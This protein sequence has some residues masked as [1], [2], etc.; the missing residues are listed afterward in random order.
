MGTSP[1]FSTLPEYASSTKQTVNH[2][3]AFSFPWTGSPTPK[4]PE[5]VQKMLQGIREKSTSSPVRSGQS[6]P[7]KRVASPPLPSWSGKI[8][9]QTAQTVVSPQPRKDWSKVGSGWNSSSSR[10][11]VGMGLPRASPILM[12]TSSIKSAP[13]AATGDL[14]YQTVVRQWCFAQGTGSAQGQQ[15]KYATG[16]GDGA[17][18]VV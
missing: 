16:R 6:S 11:A 10:V 14:I 3:P 9:H 13:A 4:S 7:V 17:G 18:L 8:N 1:P 5:Q 12:N 15:A 2:R